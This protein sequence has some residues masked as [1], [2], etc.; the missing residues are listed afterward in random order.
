M[1]I[2]LSITALFAFLIIVTLILFIGAYIKYTY[3]LEEKEMGFED[4]PRDEIESY[5]CPDDCGGEVTKSENHIWSCDNCDWS[6]V[7]MTIKD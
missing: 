3:Y 1:K 2:F 6:P 7:S 4:N 5:P